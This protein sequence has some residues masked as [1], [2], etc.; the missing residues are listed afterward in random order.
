[1]T[2]R[3]LDSRS[4]GIRRQKKQV[5]SVK[6]RQGGVFFLSADWVKK[7]KNKTSTRLPHR[8]RFLTVDEC[9]RGAAAAVV[10]NLTFS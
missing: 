8:L 4:A 7:T 9:R 3:E 1:M 5:E 6:R 10:Q 2:G